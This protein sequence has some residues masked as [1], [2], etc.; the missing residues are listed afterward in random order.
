MLN[1]NDS[2]R[3]N[4]KTLKDNG[5]KIGIGRVAKLLKQLKEGE[6]VANE[7][8][9][10]SGTIYNVSGSYCPQDRV[11]DTNTS[12]I[13]YN[14]SII[15]SNYKIET[16]TNQPS[17]F[18]E[19]QNVRTQNDIISD[20]EEELARLEAESYFKE[21]TVNETE[22]D[23]ELKLKTPSFGDIT[24]EEREFNNDTTNEDTIV[25]LE[26]ERTDDIRGWKF[27]FGVFGRSNSQ[28]I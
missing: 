3:N 11:T 5:V 10:V 2:V 7:G 26:K 6:S 25:H 18:C 21:V 24:E 28:S 22:E 9:E 8:N 17:K 15:P 13:E 12:D 16:L 4:L 23:M 14:N 1:A 19:R 20:F 27:D